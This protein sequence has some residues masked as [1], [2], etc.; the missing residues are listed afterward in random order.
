[1]LLSA[2]M[3]LNLILRIT[4]FDYCNYLVTGGVF[5]IADVMLYKLVISLDTL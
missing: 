5:K 3:W 1:M 4:T 2:T